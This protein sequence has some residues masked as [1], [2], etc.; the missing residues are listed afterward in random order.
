M[1]TVTK[2]NSVVFIRFLLF[3]IH[4]GVFVFWVFVARWLCFDVW[5]GLLLFCVLLCEL[6]FVVLLYCGF[7]LVLV[8]LSWAFV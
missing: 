4:C 2:I 7:R 6:A 5:F 8:C 1:F 3:C